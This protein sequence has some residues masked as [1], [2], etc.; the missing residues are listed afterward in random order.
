M[1]SVETA[2]TPLVTHSLMVH[3]EAFRVAG[4]GFLASCAPRLSSKRDVLFEIAYELV[5]ASSHGE[6]KT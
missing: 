5:G 3:V 2:L 1:L 6:E 4:T